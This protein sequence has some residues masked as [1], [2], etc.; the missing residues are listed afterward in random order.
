MT[1]P[2]RPKPTFTLDGSRIS[3][4]DDF[5]DEVSRVLIPG[6]PWGRNLD[7]FNDVL[8]GGFG[9]PPGGFV[10]RWTHAAH[11]I[12]HLGHP[13]TTRYLERLLQTCH[14]S[15]RPAIT[16]RLDDARHGKGPTLFD[17]LVTILSAH[18][19]GGQEEQDGIELFIETD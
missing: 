14:P 4:L 3:S 1:T 17:E 2:R 5:F 7:A 15:N 6:A 9:T 11:S 8:S 19:P 18:T 10:L 16:R 12:R 13:E